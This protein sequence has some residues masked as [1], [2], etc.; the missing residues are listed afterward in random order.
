MLAWLPFGA[1]RVPAGNARYVSCGVPDILTSEI[2]LSLTTPT[3]KR[4]LGLRIS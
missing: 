2:K 3:S 4:I 1:Q